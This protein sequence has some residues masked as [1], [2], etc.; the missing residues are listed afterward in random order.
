MSGKH[1]FLHTVLLFIVGSSRESY[2]VLVGVACV[3]GGAVREWWEELREDRPLRLEGEEE[4][5]EGEAHHV[6]V[7]C[8]HLDCQACTL[9]LHTEQ[10]LPT[11]AAASVCCPAY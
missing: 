11:V 3:K 2:G 4:E 10:L 1:L 7:Q 6:L 9:P 5:E 8:Y